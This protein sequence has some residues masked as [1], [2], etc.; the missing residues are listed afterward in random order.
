M[1]K[2]SALPEQLTNHQ[3]AERAS[4]GGWCRKMVS[5]QSFL[6]SRSCP[7]GAGA[8]ARIM[9][10]AET[11][12]L[13]HRSS[14]AS[15]LVGFR[16][17]TLNTPRTSGSPTRPSPH[18]LRALYALVTDTDSY[19]ERDTRGSGDCLA[20]A[21]AARRAYSQAR[22]RVIHLHAARAARAAQGRAD[23]P[24]GDEPRRSPRT[25]H[26]RAPATRH[27]AAKRPL[28]VRQRRALQGARPGEEGMAA[29][30]DA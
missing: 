2:G 27:L 1:G 26:A 12:P 9:R 22:R 28:R 7:A 17:L 30:P 16:G 4:H 8:C 24:R 14:L 10:G 25:A 11:A 3:S 23:R 19:V 15:R 5:G 18:T 13:A 21:A 20:Q 6:D 29:R